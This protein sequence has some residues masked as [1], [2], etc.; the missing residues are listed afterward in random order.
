MQELARELVKLKGLEI[1]HIR[2]LIENPAASDIYHPYSAHDAYG[3]EFRANGQLG[4]KV[5]AAAR[6][7]LQ[8]RGF[9]TVNGSGKEGG[10]R[11][12]VAIKPEFGL[13]KLTPYEKKV[14]D[15]IKALQTRR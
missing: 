15:L 9:E 8:K 12:R 6:E 2:P 1:I 13:E 11:L 4:P 3:V 7:L 5:L 14:F 10:E